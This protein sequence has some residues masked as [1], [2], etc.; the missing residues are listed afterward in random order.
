MK[1]QL[2]FLVITL[3]IICTFSTTAEAQKRKKKKD[4]AATS[5][6]DRKD[7]K[8]KDSKIKPYEDVI[9]ADAVSAEGLFAVHTVGE[10][11]YFEISKD[12][13]DREI[14]IVSRISGFVKNL[15]FGGAGVKSRPQ[16]VIRWQKK[17]DKILLRSVSYNSVASMEDP[18]YESV[19]NNNFEPIIATFELAAYNADSTAYVIDVASLF[20]KDV[21][22]IGAITQQQRKMFEIS[23][24]DAGRSLISSMKAYPENV[25]VRHILTYKGKK[26]PDNNITQ[27]LSV[28]MNQSFIVLPET[29]MQPRY[30]DDRVG[31]FSIRQTDYSSEAHYTDT[32]RYITRWRLEPKDMEAYNRGELV[33]PKKQIVYY[34]DP[35]TPTKWVKHIK[36]GIDDWTV[37]FEAAGFK[38][39]IVGKVAPT[40]AENEEWSAEDT[41]YSV[42]RYVSTEIQNA[43]GPHVHDPRT[44]E[45]LESDIIWYHNIQKLLR[46][47]FMTQTAGANPAAQKVKFDDA[48]MGELIRFVSAHE[49][50]HTLGLPHNMG[51][52]VAYPVD[53]LR[54]PTFTAT[55]G[56]APSIMDYARFNHIAQPGDGVKNYFPQ[57]GEYDIW[58]IIYGY[59]LV[60]TANSADAEKAT[61]NQWIKERADDPVYRYGRQRGNTFDPTSQTEDLGDDSMRSGEYGI[62]NLKRILPKLI[63][64]SQEA[65]GAGN[66]YSQLEEMYEAVYGQMGK[67]VRHV[68][69][70]IG[71]VIEKAKSTDQAG[72][73][74]TP[75]DKN[76]QQRAMAFLDKQLFQTPNWMLDKEILQRIEPMGATERLRRF[77]GRALNALFDESRLK[78]IDENISLYGL[79][80]TYTMVDLFEESRASIFTEV[81]SG[82]TIDGFRQNLQ[83]AYIDK[84]ADLMKRED[85]DFD[86]TSAKAIARGTL[87]S[88][89]IEI[90]SAAGRQS[91]L[92]TKYHLEDLV[93][94]IEMVLNPE[95]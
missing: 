64:W 15:N 7:K 21:P 10:K 43:M 59:K 48:L 4:K 18:I 12:I 51:A 5:A 29:P 71:G 68:T 24:L 46:N 57:I 41:R 53:S 63:T 6:T 37:A 11:N 20:T 49:V 17:G 74:Y 66:D 72:V 94:R 13:L 23:G 87:K 1:K 81:N 85:A 14:L 70:N 3:L 47:W 61:L 38:N 9:T 92:N 83:R 76:T 73:I 39:A 86:R 62:A 67:Y 54:S 56:T 89:Q 42:L 52:S 90:N 22:M 44:G 36:Q 28:E 91:D 77:Q 65:A 75:V 50:G 33:E 40:P 2:Y 79:T 35:A 55:H 27:T 84:L 69:T 60:P 26:L 80:N 78:R 93:E 95:K 19:R 32:K 82:G 58:S 25:E 45:I 31:Y 30:Y 34:I 88:L 16:Q 8:K